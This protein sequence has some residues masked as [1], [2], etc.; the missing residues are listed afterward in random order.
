MKLVSARFEELK[1][2]KIVVE[3]N[4]L[5]M[6][7]NYSDYVDKFE[8]LRACVLLINQWEFSDEYFIASFISGLGEELQ[9]FIRMFN[10]TTLCQA[11]E[12]GKN[13][14]LT[15]EALTKKLKNSYRAPT[16][17][18]QFARRPETNIS[19][20]QKGNHNISKT[21]PSKLLTAAEMEA[22]REK[23]LCY[24]CD[25]KYTPGHRCK[26][27]ISYLIMTE[28]EEN[29]LMTVL[30]ESNN[31]AE[32]KG[33]EE[34]TVAL[35]AISGEG[36]LTT[37]RV[38]GEVDGHHINILIDSGST[39]SFISETTTKALKCKLEPVKPLLVKV[40]NGQ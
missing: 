20:P 27:M 12:L 16:A 15:L 9:S 30:E 40:A 18:N 23:W 24:N 8:E 11:I 7:G 34:I 22:R 39:L 38:I 5:R 26:Q 1:E 31:E 13:Q 3:F 37:M 14:L 10:P 36:R 32:V 33:L 6:Y 4:K 2:T 19:P 21:P 35:S 29:N 28:E 17:S 25:E